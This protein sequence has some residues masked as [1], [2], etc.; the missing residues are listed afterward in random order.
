MAQHYT[1][2]DVRKGQEV[3]DNYGKYQ[4][5]ALALEEHGEPVKLMLNIDKPAPRVGDV[6]YGN[7]EEFES[8][9]RTYYMLKP[10]PKPEQPPITTQEAIQSQ[11]AIGQAVQCYLAGEP[12]AEAYDNIE[13]EAK[14]FYRMI[15][16]IRGDA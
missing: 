5:Y 4:N 11:W 16:N 3:E 2:R 13:R 9:S 10:C 12:S 8:G 15:N 14:H 6:V 1:I 7:L